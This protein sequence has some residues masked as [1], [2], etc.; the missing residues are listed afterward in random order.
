MEHQDCI[1]GTRVALISKT[2][3]CN[4]GAIKGEVETHKTHGHVVIVEWDG[5]ALQKV[6]LRSLITEAEGI[7]QDTLICE[8]EERFK[9]EWD[10]TL[11][12]INAKIREATTA[13]NEAA[14]LASSNNES[15]R[16]VLSYEETRPFKQ[17]LDNA[18]WSS[19]SMSC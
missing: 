16:E 13:I 1:V 6:T 4:K 15:L 7:T 19:S 17:A 5:G 9:N 14:K 12:T 18:G 3:P 10:K 11:A 8:E 2:Q